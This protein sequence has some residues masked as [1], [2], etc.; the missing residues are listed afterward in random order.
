MSS[1]AR[2]V[3][4]LAI[5]MTACVSND[6]A[7]DGLRAGQADDF[8]EN[9]SIDL[10]PADPGETDI[11]G[12]PG[13][14]SLQ[15]CIERFDAHYAG[16]DPARSFWHYF[17][18]T[19]HV[20]AGHRV[21]H[22]FPA[23]SGE[24]PL[25]GARASAIS[26][27]LDCLS[28]KPDDVDGTK[29]RSIEFDCSV[30][31][32]QTT[33]GWDTSACIFGEV[34]PNEIDAVSAGIGLSGSAAY[35]FGALF[36]A[37]GVG[38]R[39]RLSASAVDRANAAKIATS[40]ALFDAAVGA[41]AATFDKLLQT[42]GAPSGTVGTGGGLTL[43][44]DRLGEAYLQYSPNVGLGG[45]AVSASLTWL[46]INPTNPAHTTRSHDQLEGFIGGF[47]WSACGSA[48][49]TACYA[50]SGQFLD[51]GLWTS[52][53][54]QLGFTWPPVPS[55]GVSWGTTLPLCS[56]RKDGTKLA[57][58]DCACPE[59]AHLTTPPDPHDA[60]CAC[61][62]GFE[63]D[64][65]ATPR[66]PVDALFDSGFRCKPKAAATCPV[67]QERVRRQDG[68]FECQKPDPCHGGSLEAVAGDER[69]ECT[70]ARDTAIKVR[71]SRYVKRTSYFGVCGDDRVTTC[72]T[73]EHPAH[74]WGGGTGITIDTEQK[75]CAR[76][77]S[78]PDTSTC[79]PKS[80]NR[81]LLVR[82]VPRTEACPAEM[83]QQRFSDGMIVLGGENLVH[84]CGDRHCGA[85][86][87]L[88]RRRVDVT[89]VD[90]AYART[91][92][93]VADGVC[94]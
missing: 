88:D 68:S 32:A 50:H 87:T 60:T 27:M 48:L 18:P 78:T 41:E 67:G 8:P 33:R 5:G 71:T 24:V 62:D 1:F 49:L 37:F 77:Q 53:G 90:A 89:F 47:G 73:I 9:P 86:E 10:G 40:S 12:V 4:A 51:G 64:T 45:S 91:P 74:H 79:G 25:P 56:T 16:R 19:P 58:F 7:D 3:L 55:V 35:A 81:W 42:L 83:T 82:V 61:D 63:P 66:N 69:F 65:D 43:T 84:T 94:E 11:L 36:G 21:F 26:F 38:L 22:S 15:T 72:T 70:F 85:E 34:M 46:A 76:L 6:P 23:V 57:G 93:T 80:P 28:F 75:L 59:N 29:R 31:T 17:Y 13:Y 30:K 20:Y 2:A 92:I 39:S 52:G 54:M 14:R 44:L